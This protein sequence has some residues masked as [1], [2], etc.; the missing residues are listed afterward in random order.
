MEN[1]SN[2]WAWVGGIIVLIIVVGGLWWWSTSSS[3][4]N[5]TPSTTSTQLPS[6]NTGA[7]VNTGA[8]TSPSGY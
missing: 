5:P 3:S 2:V 8:S 7:T 4:Q 6:D 1:S